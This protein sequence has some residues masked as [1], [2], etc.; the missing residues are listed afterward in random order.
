MRLL[1][2]APERYDL[3]IRL[4]SLGHIERVYRRA[5]ELVRGPDVLDL[6]CGTGNMTLRLARLGLRVVGVDLSPEMLAVARRKAP[7]GSSARFVQTSAVELTDRFPAASFDTIVSILMFSE[8]TEAEQCLVLRQCRSLLRPGGQLILADE[9]RASAM[10]RRAFQNLVRL[11]LSFIAYVLT[12][13]STS[14]VVNLNG[15]LREAG[16]SIIMEESNWLG[17]FMLVE[18]RKRET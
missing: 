6:G 2:S 8:L 3:G 10:L 16:F 9:V 13:A 7:S 5:T 11:P 18:A 14:P 1:E 17:D 15:K 4:L 12:Q